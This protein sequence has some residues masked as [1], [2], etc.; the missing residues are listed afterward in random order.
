M[1]CELAPVLNVLESQLHIVIE[2]AENRGL[3]AINNDLV[4]FL[5]V[6]CFKLERSVIV[7]PDN[8]SIS[9]I[10]HVKLAEVFLDF[11]HLP[12]NPAFGG[13]LEWPVPTSEN[14]CLKLNSLD[15]F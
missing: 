3:E 1:F 4:L 10:V 12:R 6:I 13:L 2:Q 9:K 8:L 11:V 14:L 7:Q 5:Q 15:D